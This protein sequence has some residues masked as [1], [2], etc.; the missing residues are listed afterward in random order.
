MS[1]VKKGEHKGSYYEL[2]NVRYFR[3]LSEAWK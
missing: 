3:S 1:V 2:I